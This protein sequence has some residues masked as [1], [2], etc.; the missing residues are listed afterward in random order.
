MFRGQAPDVWALPRR[1]GLAHLS[2]W[3]YEGAIRNLQMVV[4]LENDSKQQVRRTSEVRRT[5]L[6]CLAP[7]AGCVQSTPVG[8]V[9]QKA[10][11]P[12]HVVEHAKAADLH[13]GADH[14][15]EPLDNVA[16]LFIVDNVSELERGIVAL[17]GA[18]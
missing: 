16:V 3:S 1:R 17:P 9:G 18:A 12:R 14:I 2:Q 13:F 6:R 7:L 4:D 8:H 5:Y 11:A 10:Q 15:R